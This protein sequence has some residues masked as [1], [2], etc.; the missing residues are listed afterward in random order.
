[1]EQTDFEHEKPFLL[2]S[3][4]VLEERQGNKEAARALLER[5]LKKNPLHSHSWQ[6]RPLL[7]CSCDSFIGAAEAEGGVSA[8]SVCSAVDWA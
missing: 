1:M 3:L 4:A 7:K 2:Q 8:P 5:A 6:A